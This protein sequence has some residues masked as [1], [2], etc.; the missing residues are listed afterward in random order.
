MD[1]R[2]PRS[3]IS[4]PFNLYAKTERNTVYRLVNIGA[5]ID[6]PDKLSAQRVGLERPSETRMNELVSLV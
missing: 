2:V 5:V 3:T 1:F 4:L 6:V